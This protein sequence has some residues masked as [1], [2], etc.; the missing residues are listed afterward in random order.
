MVLVRLVDWEPRL[1]AVV[2][3]YR[4]VPFRWGDGD[5]VAFA[6]AAIAA[7]TGQ[8][9]RDEVPA[10]W[11]PRRAHELVQQ[12]DMVARVSAVLGP[13]VHRATL[14]RGDLVWDPCAEPRG[15]IPGAVGVCLGEYTAWRQ[16]PRGLVETPTAWSEVGWRVG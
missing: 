15:S 13:P 11:T 12:Q 1:A 7:V 16:T 6:V 3:A 9:L 2:E 5:C 10:Y 8:D 4:T 14:R